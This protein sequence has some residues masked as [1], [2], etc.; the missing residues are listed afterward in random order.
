MREEMANCPHCKAW[1]NLGSAYCPSCR[2]PIEKCRACGFFLTHG[3]T[4]CTRCGAFVA[5]EPKLG[6]SA[7][8]EGGM[9]IGDPII[10]KLH[11]ENTGNV[12]TDIE[13]TAS[14]PPPVK[15]ETVEESFDSLLPWAPIQRA[16][17][18]K[19]DK[20]GEYTIDKIEVRYTKSSKEKEVLKVQPVK[21]HV[22]GRPI[23][24]MEV[25]GD[26]M[27]LLG[28]ETELLVNLRNTGTAPAVASRIEVSFPTSIHITGP[29]LVL[30]QIE[31]ERESM[32]I[33]KLTP[34]F[35]GE[36]TIKLKTVYS[37]QPMGHIAP[38]TFES[39]EKV[40]NLTVERKPKKKT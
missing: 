4:N 6:A 36:H 26:S 17:E 3:S 33:L 8:V 35:T 25:E 22:H 13:I 21:F 20:P 29:T 19:V 1:I 39:A 10:L 18:L 30:P 32:G 34:L 38:V 27:M 24:Q 11:L 2:R 28:D 12:P 37:S 23:I 14:C 9:M 15:P 40:L 7:W 31:P 16:Y 5:K